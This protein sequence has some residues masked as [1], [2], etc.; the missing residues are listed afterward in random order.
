MTT[1]NPNVEGTY[2]KIITADFSTG[3][4]T[5][6]IA[7]FPSEKELD[8]TFPFRNTCIFYEPSHDDGGSF[9]CDGYDRNREMPPE[10]YEKLKTYQNSEEWKA[11]KYDYRELMKVVPGL[12]EYIFGSPSKCNDCMKRMPES[13]DTIAIKKQLELPDDIREKAMAKCRAARTIIYEFPRT[14]D[15]N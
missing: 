2:K 5:R 10:L 11:M 1:K 12:E 14:T 9:T 8:I 6:I 15:E 7:Y 13:E 4:K 3:E